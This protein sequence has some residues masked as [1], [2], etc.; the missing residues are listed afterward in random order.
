MTLSEKITSLRTAHNMSQGDL[1]EKLNVSRQSVSKWE[2]GAST[3]DLEK[4]IAMSELFHITLD[5]L[6]KGSSDN[7][8]NDIYNNSQIIYMQAPADNTGASSTQRMVGFILLITGIL[9]VFLEFI[10]PNGFLF[11]ILGT[12][13][14]LCSILCLAVKKNAGMKIAWTTAIILFVFTMPYGLFMTG[15]LHFGTMAGCVT[16]GT[17]I[18]ILVLII[19]TLIRKRK[20]H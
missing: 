3:P 7:S 13:I 2:T 17:W 18:Y 8:S 10:A 12:Y 4:L 16:L 14:I 5:E 1:A 11:T 6:A 15:G 20:K 19:V 9:C